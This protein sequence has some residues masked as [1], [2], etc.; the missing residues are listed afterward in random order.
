MY[1]TTRYCLGFFIALVFCNVTY[2]QADSTGY[3]PY[4]KS[5][6]VVDLD[7]IGTIPGL[8]I[9]WR[10]NR[11]EYGISSKISFDDSSSSFILAPYA[12]YFLK[13][14]AFEPVPYLEI[15]GG[16][17][18][19]T[20]LSSSVQGLSTLLSAG[21]INLGLSLKSKYKVRIYM[22]VGLLLLASN[23][24]ERLNDGLGTRIRTRTL[25]TIWKTTLIGFQF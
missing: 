18:W 14:L 16:V 2:G 3:V 7:L 13:E 17:G 19:N 4:K 21:G 11:W 22:E 15:Y 8:E 20:G 23:R 12:S 24:D 25:D 9:G 1:G 6:L 10:N 5:G